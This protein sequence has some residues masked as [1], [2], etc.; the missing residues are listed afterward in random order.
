MIVHIVDVLPTTLLNL[1]LHHFDGLLVDLGLEVVSCSLCIDLVN[2]VL[3]V[4]SGRLLGQP[5]DQL[6][7]RAWLSSYGIR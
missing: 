5:I 4:P 2:C 1:I 7:V 6:V 3:V